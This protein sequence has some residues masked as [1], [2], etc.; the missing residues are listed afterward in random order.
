M[1]QRRVTLSLSALPGGERGGECSEARACA[2]ARGADPHLGRRKGEGTWP[3]R[4]RCRLTGTWLTPVQVVCEGSVSLTRA[5]S[6][7]S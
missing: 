2:C 1:R 5:N 3:S 4:G 6:V 7:A